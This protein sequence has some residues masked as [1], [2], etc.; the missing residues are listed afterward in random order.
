M[1]TDYQ[2]T[3]PI[4][5]QFP[6]FAGG[7]FI[8]NCLALSRHCVPQD[9]EIAEHLIDNPGDYAYRL[10]SVMR[11]LPPASDMI[12]WIN[13]Y[14]LGDRQLFGLV[15]RKWAQG[16]LDDSNINDI[17]KR[18]SIA[19]MKFFISCHSGP[20]QVSNLLKVWP[21]ASIVMLVNHRKF[22]LISA[23]LKSENDNVDAHAGNYC[24]SKYQQLAGTDWP[25]W[26]EFENI[27]FDINRLTGYPE[28]ILTEIGQFY[29]WNLITTTPAMVDIDSNIFD[30]HK[31]LHMIQQLYSDLRLDDFNANL[32]GTFWKS[33]IN[34]HVDIADIL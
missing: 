32:V 1:E 19:N 27:G 11:T 18:L 29:Q 21:R 8:M 9:L 20:D 6:R 14:E 2:S 15:V 33:Y 16:T 22:S 25:T 26:T 34:L 3:N 30:Q 23:R 4:V 24:Q 13:C 28:H 7:K 5:V 17:T 10:S 31:F 12:N